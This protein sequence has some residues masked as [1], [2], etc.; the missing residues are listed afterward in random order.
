MFKSLKL[1]SVSSR[2]LSGTVLIY[3]NVDID[4][5]IVPLPLNN[6]LMMPGV[7]KQHYK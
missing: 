6:E 4:L 5:Y 2:I 1:V 7:C 3:L